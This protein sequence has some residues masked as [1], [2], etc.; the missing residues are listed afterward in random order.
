M[1]TNKTVACPM[2]GN[3]LPLIERKGKRVAICNCFTGGVKNRWSGQV[4]YSEDLP[5]P[6]TKRSKS[7]GNK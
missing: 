5:K 3:Q 1:E 6:K 7:G 4:V 2:H